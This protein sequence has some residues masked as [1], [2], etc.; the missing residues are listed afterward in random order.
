MDALVSGSAINDE[1]RLSH[2]REVARL[3]RTLQERCGDVELI[4]DSAAR[5]IVDVARQALAHALR[6]A[7]AAGGEVVEVAAAD[8]ERLPCAPRAPRPIA[9]R[10][11]SDGRDRRVV[12]ADLRGAIDGMQAATRVGRGGNG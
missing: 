5:R 1:G 4:T 6:L 8:D 11:A 9:P 7:G 12:I 3:A 10:G 2:G